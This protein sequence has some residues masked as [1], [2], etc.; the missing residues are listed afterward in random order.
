MSDPLANLAKTLSPADPQTPVPSSASPFTVGKVAT[1]N[2]DGTVTANINAATKA[3]TVYWANASVPKV[4]QKILVLGSPEGVQYAT[5]VV[6][7]ATELPP[8]MA[9]YPVGAIYVSTLATNPATL[10][11]FGTWSTYAAGRTLIGAGTSDATYAAGATGGASTF[12]ITA[13]YLPVAPPWPLPNLSHSHPASDGTN[14]IVQAGLSGGG[15]GI[16]IGGSGYVL[17]QTGSW[18]AYVTMGSQASGGG[19]ALPTVPPYIVVY[20]WTRT[21]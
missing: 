13:S 16:T 15:A 4:G 14:N 5:G 17:G 21:A 20:W 11:G 2:V 6:G 7:S 1:V 3:S 9:A 19:T 12:V 18:P 10:L 8:L